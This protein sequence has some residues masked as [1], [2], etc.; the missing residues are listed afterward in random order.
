MPTQQEIAEHLG[1]TQQAVSAQMQPL[2]LDWR[3]ESME[4]IRLRYLD[5][6]RA[7]AGGHRSADGMDLARERALTEQVDREL[8]QLTLAEKKG[9]VVNVLQLEPELQRMFVAFRTEL[10]ARDDKLKSEID[11]VYGIDVDLSFIHEHTRNALTQLARYDA[12]GE[13]AAGQAGEG[14]AAAGGDDD[15]GV[16]AGTPPAIG[17]GDGQ[18]GRLQP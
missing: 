15:D 8:K 13:G 10:L 11:A 9:Q 16:G 4:R 7:V 2:G 18:A 17:E 14:S 5:H 6:L 12:G 1:I 3:N